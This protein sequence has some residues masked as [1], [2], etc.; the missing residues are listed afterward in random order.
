MATK[1]VT[2]RKAA[3]IY[4]FK[5]VDG[6]PDG[7][8]EAIV[9]VFNNVDFGG[10]RIAPGFFSKSLDA[11]RSTGDPIPVIFSHQWDN[12]D[13]HVGTANPDDVAELAPGDPLLPDSLKELGGLYVKA[14][15]DIG[16]PFAG[17]L[18]EK[19]SSR[20][21]KEF[22]FAYDV[23]KAKPGT[24]GAT[25]ELLEGDLIEVGPTLKGMNPAT[26]LISA[27]TRASIAGPLEAL[28][29]VEELTKAL[30]PDVPTPPAKALPGGLL[31]GSVE[32]GVANVA[33]AAEVW[34]A[35]EYGRDLF[36]VHVEGTFPD[37]NRAVVTAE[38]WEDA[39]G[40]G[41]VWALSYTTDDAG[42]VTIEEA[43]ELELTVELRSKRAER[44]A[45]VARAWPK[46][47]AGARGPADTLPPETSKGKAEAKSE[48]EEPKAEDPTTRTTPSL[49]P[50]VALALVDTLA[51]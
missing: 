12:L 31:A 6:A 17:R 4:G 27:K 39:W 5:A 33:R 13:A 36:A 2:Q 29:I 11:W 8:F 3:P 42:V 49:S 37:D 7:T 25:L 43:T 20:A 23:T 44:R 21:I 41:P 18:W 30:E 32:D 22:S 47:S 38:R 50:E 26:A 28:D 1:R 51:L 10:D 46:A 45:A 9:A 24:H 15:M 35:I 40:E 19:M 34:A 14:T 16:Q 48:L